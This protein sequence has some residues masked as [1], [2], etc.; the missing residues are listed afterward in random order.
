M[1]YIKG[2]LVNMYVQAEQTNQRTGELIPEA[3]YIQILGKVPRRGGNTDI[4]T[5][6]LKVSD[7]KPYR[8]L[9]GK[10]IMIPIQFMARDN[11]AFPYVPQGAT[12]EIVQPVKSA[13]A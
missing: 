12:P 6:R 9:S 4:Q 2:Q 10:E 5:V 7:L 8:P 13:A 11:R 3:S 1:Y